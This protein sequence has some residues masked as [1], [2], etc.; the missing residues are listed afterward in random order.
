ML[1]R[2]Y[3]QT[4]TCTGI[5]LFVKCLVKLKDFRIRREAKNKNN[6]KYFY[7]KYLYKGII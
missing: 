4:K 5:G 2:A 1:L 7:L 6:K 3:D